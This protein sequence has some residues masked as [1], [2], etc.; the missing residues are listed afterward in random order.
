MENGLIALNIAGWLA[1]L[2]WLVFVMCVVRSKPAAAA[3]A[4]TPAPTPAPSWDER[5]RRVP[6]PVELGAASMWEQMNEVQP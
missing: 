6:R 2:A 4:P 5:V 1:L 3:A